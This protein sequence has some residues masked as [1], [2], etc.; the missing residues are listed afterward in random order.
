MPCT[1]NTFFP[2]LL[3]YLFHQRSPFTPLPQRHGGVNLLQWKV[4]PSCLNPI[5]FK[6]PNLHHEVSLTIPAHRNLLFYVEAIENHYLGGWFDICHWLLYSV[7]SQD[8]LST[9]YVFS[10]FAQ[11]AHLELL[12]FPIA[13][14]A[15]HIACM[16]LVFNKCFNWL[17]CTRLSLGFLLPFCPLYYFE[18]SSL[19]VKQILPLNSTCISWVPFIPEAPNCNVCHC[20]EYQCRPSKWYACLTTHVCIWVYVQISQKASILAYNLYGLGEINSLPCTS[21]TLYISF[22]RVFFYINPQGSSS[23]K[24]SKIFMRV[25]YR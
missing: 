22:W 3:T 18:S 10:L 12:R 21:S 7:I 5:C 19:K 24:I 4:F 9:F 17:M 11:E 1:L 23:S 13:L 25:V 8:E 20:P 6:N 2:I 15:L 16:Q 14:Y